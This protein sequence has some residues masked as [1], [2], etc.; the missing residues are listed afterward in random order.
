M[1]WFTLLLI[2][3]FFVLPLI[4]QIAGARKRGQEPPEMEVEEETEWEIVDGELRRRSPRPPVE[5]E[6]GAVPAPA[7]VPAQRP[8]GARPSGGGGGGG[9]TW[10]EGWTPWP[11]TE[12]GGAEGEAPQERREPVTMRAP[13]QEPPVRESRPRRDPAREAPARSRPEPATHAPPPR[14]EPVRAERVERVREERTVELRP[15]PVDVVDVD[16]RAEQRRLRERTR[17]VA[18][19]IR[20]GQGAAERLAVSVRNPSELRRAI[21][22][23]EVLGPPR[24]L[25]PLGEE[26][27]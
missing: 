5:P 22:L 20:R 7:P 14:V 17:V 16:R 2:F 27:E 6:R 26:R 24:S 8:G 11:G 21:L 10:S 25:R 23:S 9:A 18:T 4:Q 13:Q 15:V 12:P 1:D 19:V 3:I